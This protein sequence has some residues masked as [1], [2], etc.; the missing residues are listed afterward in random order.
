MKNNEQ[1][2]N[3]KMDD[4]AMELEELMKT[5]RDLKSQISV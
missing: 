1:N 3:L 2:D 5:N 4:L